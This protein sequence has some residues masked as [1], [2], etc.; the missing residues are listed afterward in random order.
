M[1]GKRGSKNFWLL[2]QHCDRDID[3][4]KKC[5][6]LFKQAVKNNQADPK[7][8]AYL[9]DRVLLADG[10]KQ[11]F[12]TQ[13]LIRDNK[14]VLAPTVN[15]ASINKRRLSHGLDTIEENTIRINKVYKSLLE[16][17]A[18]K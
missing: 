16:K 11:K 7:Y 12:G 10:K 5:L 14:T 18:K 9:T 13:F 6:E 17:K 1:I 3:F 2:V 8:F 4:Q 15:L